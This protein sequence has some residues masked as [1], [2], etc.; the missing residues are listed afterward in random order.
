MEVA[1]VVSVWR[2]FQQPAITG[3]ADYL[4]TTDQFLTRLV[5][6]YP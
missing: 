4:V 2:P 6:V 1:P 5:S 3:K